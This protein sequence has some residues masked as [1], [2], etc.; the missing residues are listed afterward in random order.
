MLVI[1]VPVAVWMIRIWRHPVQQNPN[2][3]CCERAA[4]YRGLVEAPAVD[5]QLS[6]SSLKF[7]QRQTSIDE[8]AKR[9]IATGA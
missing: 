7:R 4:I 2:S 8:R 5:T 6:Q 1:V 9:H 3:C